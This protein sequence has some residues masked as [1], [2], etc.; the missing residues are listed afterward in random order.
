MKAAPFRALISASNMFRRRLCPPSA[1]AEDGLPEFSANAAQQQGNDLH[2]REEEGDWQEDEDMPANEKRA[3][4]KNARLTEAFVQDTFASLEITDPG[5]VKIFKERE[6]FLC[7]ANGEPVYPAVP[8]HTD[9]VRWYPKVKILFC[10]DSKFGRSPVARAEINYQ[11]RVYFVMCRDD[12]GGERVYCAIRQPYLRGPDEFHSVEYT[13][14]QTE[15][16]REEILEIIAHCYSP[17]AKRRP[18]IDACTY[19]RAQGTSRCPESQQFIRQLDQII[20]EK[21]DPEKLEAL[22]PD[23]VAAKNVINAWEDRMRWV[24]E[25]FPEMLHTYKLGIQQYVDSVKNPT[26]A[27]NRLSRFFPRG[28]EEF[29]E[30]CCKPSLPKLRVH[31]AKEH[32]MT[33]EAAKELLI[34]ELGQAFEGGEPVEDAL[35]ISKPKARSLI[36]RK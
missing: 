11:L 3:L 9:E 7:D 20:V 13:A 8:G 10:F 24:A 32:D 2:G 30:V 35:I 6:F 19:C 31:L 5:P 33:E 23:I 25:R 26:A 12:I 28:L 29:V 1:I 21:L 34:T 16:A 18:S 14:D 17:V 36:K 15:Q 22:G 4:E 27:H